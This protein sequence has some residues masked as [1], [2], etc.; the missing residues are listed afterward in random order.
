[1]LVSAAACRRSLPAIDTV[2]DPLASTGTIS[3][4]VFGPAGPA[5]VR[6]RAVEVLNLATGERQRTTTNT[7]GS[8]TFKLKPGKYRVLLTLRE[9]ET[10]VKQPEVVTV[11]RANV[12]ARADI[13]L[14]TRRTARPRYHAPR[15]DDGLGSAIG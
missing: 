13:I 5:A 15:V 1:L 4:A 7:A 3:G 14:G 9:G 6:G 12:D 10:I 11:N 8:F 2:P